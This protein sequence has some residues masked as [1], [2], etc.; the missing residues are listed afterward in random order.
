MAA[1]YRIP[2]LPTVND[3]L[4]MYNI[5]ASKKLSQNFIMDPRLLNRM[6]R[7]MGNIEGKH[8]VEVGP[9]PGGITRSILGQGAM[10]CKLLRRIKGFLTHW[11]I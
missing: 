7:K 3:I 8:I 1:V 11:S 10:S 4:R 5:R 2:A 6:V 9:G